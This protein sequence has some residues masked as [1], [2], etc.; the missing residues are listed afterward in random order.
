MAF[1]KCMRCEC[2]TFEVVEA[3]PHDSNYKL[4]FVQCRRCGGVVGALDC[5]NIGAMLVKQ[6][7]AIQKIADHLGVKV[8]D[9]P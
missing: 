7:E 3:E 1:S 5:M 6:F 4:L 8:F 2:A 9:R